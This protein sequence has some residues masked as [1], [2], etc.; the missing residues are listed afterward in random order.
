MPTA[1]SEIA[2]TPPGVRLLSL[3]LFVCLFQSFSNNSNMQSG[4]KWSEL[5][6]GRVLPP[7]ECAHKS[8]GLVNPGAWLILRQGLRIRIY[9]Q[10]RDDVRSLVQGAQAEEQQ[11][12]GQGLCAFH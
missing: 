1:S 3:F 4:W 2:F 5:A 9:H 10:L 12:R 7:A 6:P 11:R 8:W